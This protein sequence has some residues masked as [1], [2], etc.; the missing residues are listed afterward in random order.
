M[1]R[2]ALSP[3]ELNW[4]VTLRPWIRWLR[5]VPRAARAA[6]GL[7][8]T[9]ALIRF[10][11]PTGHHRDAHVYVRGLDH[12]LHIRAG[13][14]D[15]D[16]VVD[17]FAGRYHLPLSDQKPRIVWDLGCNIGVTVAQMA[18]LYPDAT[19]IGVE[20]DPGNA[21]AARVNVRSD[22]CRIIEAAVWTTA[23]TVNLWRAPGREAGSHI[24]D[25]GIRV[26]AM[27]P[28]ELLTD[29]GPPDFVK[30]DIEGAERSLLADG[31]EWLHDVQEIRVECH[32]RYTTTD[33][34]RDLERA[35]FVAK[36]IPARFAR[37]SV[38][39]TRTSSGT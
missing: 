30:M 2:V 22:R 15:A 34:A 24:A 28:S 38:I 8:S 21:A 9:A 19:V 6:R 5:T 31:A 14:T 17:A 33:C 27:T 23:G 11:A 16:V 29:T 12:P 1:L 36:V 26:R 7:R 18:A 4:I 35:G 37:D 20:P 10:L 39:G 32:G 25:Q 3:I 13:T